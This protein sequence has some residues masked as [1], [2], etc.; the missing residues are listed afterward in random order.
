MHYKWQHESV[1]KNS[2]EKKIPAKINT[3]KIQKPSKPFH[4]TF[5][6]NEALGRT[7][8]Q[9]ELLSLTVLKRT[10]NGQAVLNQV[11]LGYWGRMWSG[12]PMSNKKPE[13][14]LLARSEKDMPL[15][16]LIKDTSISVAITPLSS[17]QESLSAGWQWSLLFHWHLGLCFAA[18]GKQNK[19]SECHGKL[20]LEKS[21]TQ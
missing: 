14:N 3:D 20:F 21:F 7:C 1:I 15:V 4:R 19:P 18:D 13:I 11:L 8:V 2:N 12:V 5:I 16:L 6:C 17:L 9:Y 10:V